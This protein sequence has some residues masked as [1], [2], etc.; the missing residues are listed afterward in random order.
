MAIYDYNQGKKGNRETP[1]A[2]E[3]FTVYL[4]L[5]KER[6]AARV[7]EILGC[8]PDNIKRMSSRNGW[9]ER[10]AIWD[11]DQVKNTFAQA[12]KER[13][14]EHRKAIKAFR[15]EQEKRAHYM[16]EL[17]D[18]MMD[19]TAEKLQAMHAAGELP[20][21][22]QISNLA[23]TVATLAEKAMDLKATA[24]GVDELIETLETELGE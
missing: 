22:Q 2:F 15:D 3:A 19:L 11:A 20:S 16:G 4:E 9:T 12:R 23:K 6:S 14:A 1:E 13:E 8:S 17:A 5:R 21:E 10:A 24:L 18:L 7:A